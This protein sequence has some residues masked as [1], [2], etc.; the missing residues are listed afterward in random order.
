MII[1][2]LYPSFG[3]LFG[4]SS[5]YL[6][7]EHCV[8]R[9][10]P[11][12]EIVRTEINDRPAFAD[13]DVDMV[14]MGCMTES[15]QEMSIEALK[16]FKD[17]IEQLIDKGTI[18]LACGN[19]VELFL[20]YIQEG[21]KKIQG[22]GIFDEYAVRYMMN[23]YNGIVLADFEGMKL[24]AFKT[25]FSMIYGDNSKEY[26]CKVIKGIGNNKDTQLEGVRRKNFLG[27]EMIGPL[28]I[29]NPDFTVYLLKLL[30]AKKPV[31]V[32]EE[33]ARQAYQKRLKE[34]EDPARV[35]VNSH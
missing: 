33:T 27:T 20:S 16:P 9:N 2:I 21:D 1:E 25:Q 13:R 5:G 35:V 34:F 23:R 32:E 22:L 8:K 19:S 18:F 26:M 30:G 31:L 11:E 14:Y 7:L 15:E 12:A 6:Y 10:F 4:E 17:R 28:V 24:T 29:L 3:N